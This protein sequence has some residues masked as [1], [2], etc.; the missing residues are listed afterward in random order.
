MLKYRVISGLYFPVFR[1]NIQFKYR[2]TRSRN[3]FVFGHFSRSDHQKKKNLR[4]IVNW[5]ITTKISTNFMVWTFCGSY[6]ETFKYF[7]HL[8]SGYYFLHGIIHL[9]RTEIFSEKLLLPTPWYARVHA[10]VS[11]WVIN[12][13]FSENFA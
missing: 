11:K 9:V 3:N 7:T 6:A 13:S 10:K 1:L 5:W 8:G 2:K 12:L 4:V